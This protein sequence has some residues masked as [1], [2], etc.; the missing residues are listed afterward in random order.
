MS[1]TLLLATRVVLRPSW[2]GR[3]WVKCLR[4]REATVGPSEK[5]PFII[6]IVGSLLMRALREETG[7][8]RFCVC[9]GLSAKGSEFLYNH[10]LLIDEGVG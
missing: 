3:F 5:N 1:V 6:T 7:Q 8:C 10:V 4:G 2:R 9:P